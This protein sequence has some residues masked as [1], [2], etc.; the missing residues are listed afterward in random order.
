MPDNNKTETHTTE[1][2][3]TV[4]IERSQTASTTGTMSS[5]G[6]NYSSRTLRLGDDTVLGYEPSAYTKEQTAA[7]SKVFNSAVGA[8]TARATNS[9]SS[10][11]VT[12]RALTNSRK[13]GGDGGSGSVSGS[14]RG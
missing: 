7:M 1:L 4:G 14:G 2:T 13:G 6:T 5:I 8:L 10:V 12:L 3:P 9:I 11:S